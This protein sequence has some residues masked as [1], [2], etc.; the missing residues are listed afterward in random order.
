MLSVVI[1]ISVFVGTVFWM[2]I[3]FYLVNTGVSRD[4]TPRI[5]IGVIITG[6]I[7]LIYYFILSNRK[8]NKK[9]NSSHQKS[10]K[11]NN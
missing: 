10:E 4:S 9:A 5:I 11:V 1:G 8:N 6:L 7:G 3:G 2:F